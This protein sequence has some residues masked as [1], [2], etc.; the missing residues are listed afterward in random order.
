MQY[1]IN[2]E[3]II[4]GDGST[5][6]TIEIVNHYKDEQINWCVWENAARNKG[7]CAAKGK[8]IVFQDSDDK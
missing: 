4:V 8:Y 5:D 3:W 1:H 6:N 2:F 7:I